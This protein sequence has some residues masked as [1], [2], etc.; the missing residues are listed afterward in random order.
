MLAAI[1]ERVSVPL[2][3]TD[4]LTIAQYVLASVPHNRLPFLAKRHKLEVGKSSTSPA[5]L[6]AKHVSRYDESSLSRL[7]LE[8]SL[9][10]LA[11]RSG[12]DAESDILLTTAKRYRIDTRRCTR[13]LLR[14]LL[15]NKTRKRRSPRPTRAR[16]RE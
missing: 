15:P 6:L 14:S 5:E 3:K 13:L 12:G 10:E 9:L 8:I 2:K 16:P 1:L 11:Y 4:L 7:L